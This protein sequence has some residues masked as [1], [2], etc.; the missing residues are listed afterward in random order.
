VDHCEAG[1][2]VIEHW[3]LPVAFVDVALNH[4]APKPECGE[5]TMLVHAACAVTD[6]LGFP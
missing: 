2:W 5:L 3:K 1:A 6:R 4:H